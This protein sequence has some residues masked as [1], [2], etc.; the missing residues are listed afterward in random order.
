MENLVGYAKTDLMVPQPP[1]GDL[2]A[3]TPRPGVVRGGQR[4]GS[5]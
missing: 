5:Q 4:H 1:F 3:A 2:T